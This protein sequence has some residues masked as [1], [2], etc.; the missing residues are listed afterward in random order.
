MALTRRQFLKWAGATGVGA[1]VFN[2]CS[3][4]DEEISVQSP[5]E[6]P[7]DLVTGRDNYYATVSPADGEGLLV[8]VMEGRAKKVEGNPDYPVNG[9]KHGVRTEGLLQALYH[10]DRIA[11][12]LTRIA[13]KVG[14]FRRMGWP[15]GLETLKAALEAADPGSVLIV[16]PPLRGALAHVVRSFANAYGARTAGFEPLGQAP[17]RRAVADVFG[18]QALP[19]FDIS[20]ANYIISFGADFLGTWVAPTRFMRGYGEFRQG[21]RER[22]RLVQVETRMSPT[23]AVADE[24][25]Y[26]NPGTEGHLAMA[27]AYVIIEDGVPPGGTDRA[28]TGGGGLGQIADYRPGAVAGAVGLPAERIVELAR[29]FA[30]PSHSPALAIGGGSA[31]AYSNGAANLRA[32]YALNHLVGA[33]NRPGGVIYNPAPEG[34]RVDALSLREWKDELERMRSGE[35]KMALIKDANLLYA[36]PAELDATGA[37]RNV[38]T[39]FSFSAFLDETAA[40]ADVILPGHTPLEEWGSDSPEPGPGYR[41]TGYQQ[42]VVRRFRDTM[43]FGD[44]LLQM[45]AQLGIEGMPG[46]TMRET[47]RAEARAA[48][49]TGRGSVRAATF[50][51]FWKRALERGGWWDASAVTRSASR[52]RQ[53]TRSVAAPAFFGDA[54]RYPFH[55]VPFEANALGVG[56]LSH[57]PW[58][59]SMP[60]P[61]TTVAWSSWV[62]LNPQTAKRMDI[63]QQDVVLVEA[64]N[65]RFIR[66]PV[67]LNP[68]TPP[69]V[70]AV[71]FG[72]GHAQFTSF[73]AGRGANLFDILSSG[74]ERDTGALAWAG[75]R[76]RVTKT[77]RRAKLP[78]LEGP[79]P[80]VQLDDQPI[81]YIQR[82]NGD[83]GA[84][85]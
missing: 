45:G 49:K 70:A 31:G 41:T 62:E 65:G 61:M 59:Q 5:L 44:V 30:D 81:I 20:R 50:E 33:A 74:E 40:A 69:D 35:V 64:S 68:A 18:Q 26:V 25:V 8:R 47:V 42:P 34:D 83:S 55:L 32:V 21:H 60:D 37:L 6:L 38:E 3:V 78:S 29:A 28:Y 39:V 14:P 84:A 51:E 19:D 56:Q 79:D 13:P 71:P 46:A 27:M 43:A 1:V 66:V 57:V 52:V 77:N 63:A 54:R 76:V 53:V 85:H 23:A 4:P 2:G 36:L 48:H 16:T 73:A 24:W 10:P 11:Q 72:Q 12:P 58:L 15:E 75:T 67:Y 9:G 80:A 22:G 17:L 7:E 82:A